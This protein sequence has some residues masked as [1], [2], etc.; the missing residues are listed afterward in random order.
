MSVWNWIQKFSQFPLYKRKRVSAF[1]ID[2]TVIQ[3]GWKNYYLWIAIE[4]VHKTI[5][6]I[7]ISEN[8]NMLVARQFLHLYLLN[9]D[10]DL[11]LFLFY[12]QIS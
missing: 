4:P 7:Y 2:E 5:L 9:L 11:V 1:I 6:G 8:R 10:Q 3:I 12:S